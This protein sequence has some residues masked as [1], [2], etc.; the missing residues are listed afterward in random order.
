M[1]HNSP[2]DWT[3]PSGPPLVGAISP[4]PPA[5]DS[6][7]PAAVSGEAE[8]LERVLFEIKKVIVGQDRAIERM[9]VCL[10]SG[11]HCLLESVPGLAK[12]LS[13]ETMAT[14]V[15][16]TFSRIQFTPDLL[17]S[18]I[19]GTR[20]YRASS[21][22]FD[23]E[24]GPVFANFLLAD[25]INRAPAKVQSAL[26]EVM[27]EHQ[28]SL[29]GNTHQLPEPFLVLA[30][31][32]PIESEGVYPLPEAQR[33]RFMMKVLLGYPSPS[34]EVAIVDRMGKTPPEPAQVISP[35]DVLALQEAARERY[36]DRS[37]I[38]YAVNLV[39][40]TRAPENFGL[41]DLRP[42]V[43]YGASP[44][45]SLALVKAGRS[46]ALL[47]GRAYVLPQDVFDVAP[48][49]LRHRLVLTYEAL[50]QDIDTEAVVTRILS[51][52]PAPRVTPAQSNG[53]ADAYHGSV[54]DAV[55]WPT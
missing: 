21:E 31:Q 51:T 7:A 11:G 40:A 54:T 22:T 18:D 52:V 6:P 42:L 38:E 10:V 55:A 8:I 45:A 3:A 27:A 24:L 17:P 20:I 47:R 43:E 9:L 2:N 34:E 28:V 53:N 35:E 25:E 32:N 41:G 48:E 14:A 15:G 36:I 39:L 30:T 1:D 46:L 49:I 4:E 16:G 13:V 5:Q 44:R 26:L 33:D 37:V 50:A 29:G 19:T 23:V 12:T